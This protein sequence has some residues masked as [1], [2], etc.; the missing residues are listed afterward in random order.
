MKE[1]TIANLIKGVEKKQLLLPTIQRGFVWEAKKIETLFDSLMRGFPI[2]SFLFWE[3]PDE[4]EHTFKFY[5]FIKDY[6]FYGEDPRSF[7][8]FGKAPHMAVLDGQ[9]RITSFYIGLK[10]SYIPKGKSEKPQKLYLNLLK[11]NADSDI[12]DDDAGLDNVYNFKFL[13]DEDAAKRDDEF[14]WFEVGKILSEKFQENADIADYLI[15]NNVVD[16]QTHS[17]LKLPYRI[18]N[19]LWSRVNTKP[20]IEYHL[21]NSKSLDEV[22]NIF[23]RINNGGKPVEL[24]EL[25]ISLATAQLKNFDVENNLIRLVNEINNIGGEKSF[26]VSNDFILKAFL[27]LCDDGNKDRESIKFT[28]EN[29]K[30]G[31]M[32]KIRAEWDK[33]SDAIKLSAK[34]VN[35]FGFNQRNFTSNN[36]LIPIAQYIY[37]NGNNPA[38]YSAEKGKMIHWFIMATLNGIFS[39]GTDNK[40]VTF[41]NRLNEN[42]EKFPLIEMLGAKNKTDKQLADELINALMSTTYKS[43]KNVLMA[44]T[45]LYN[46][47][48]NL[49]TVDVDHM[50][51]KIKIK[52]LGEISQQGIADES[53]FQTD[54]EKFCNALPNLQLLDSSENK[55]KSSTYF[56]DWVKTQPAEYLAENFVPNVDF[57][58]VNFKNFIAAREKLIRE[59]LTENLKAHGIIYFGAG[60]NLTTDNQ[61]IFKFDALTDADG[62]FFVKILYEGDGPMAY[63]YDKNYIQ[64]RIDSKLGYKL[65]EEGR[66]IKLPRAE[67]DAMKNNQS[68]RKFKD[69][70]DMATRI[71]NQFANA[72][73]TSDGKYMFYA[74]HAGVSMKVGAKK[75]NPSF[76]VVNKDLK[77]TKRVSI[78]IIT[79]EVVPQ[80]MFVEVTKDNV[81]WARKIEKAQG[82][83]MALKYLESTQYK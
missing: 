71:K 47:K 68:A 30:A 46:G 79:Q 66:A 44:L 12:G 56:S 14:F 4:D 61:K 25:L 27:V 48:K 53:K 82:V 2:S 28:V 26:N 17:Y 39:S 50:F 74:D 83:S 54:Y 32:Q 55:K 78:D 22:L 7:S 23:V 37:L 72:A 8:E 67:F 80:N 18:L 60:K 57:R 51:P 41:R 63:V 24:S 81:D 73:V 5:D 43:L 35:E 10:G 13:T 6:N 42:H 16:S 3:V 29:F 34:L 21:S 76:Y 69:I 58:L 36:A 19:R 52:N 70:F 65:I 1:L 31:K 75:W 40:L 49:A 33:M 20:V 15:E 38:A 59:T 64:Q 11:I 45:I 77:T 9:Q 62:K